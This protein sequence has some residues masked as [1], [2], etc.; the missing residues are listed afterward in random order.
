M[1]NEKENEAQGVYDELLKNGEAI[2]S[3]NTREELAELIN[4][5]PAESR[6]AVGA[7]GRTRDGSKYTIQV[8]LI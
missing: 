1:S 8:N 6:Y 2:L 3:A 4:N 5:I 7:V